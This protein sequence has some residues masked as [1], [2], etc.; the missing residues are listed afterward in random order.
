MTQPVEINFTEVALD[1]L[2]DHKGRVAL[3]MTDASSCRAS[4]PA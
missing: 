2:A 3:I 1:K 4:C